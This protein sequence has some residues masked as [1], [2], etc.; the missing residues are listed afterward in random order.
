MGKV[1]NPCFIIAVTR[2]NCIAIY[3]CL[4]S[5]CN[6]EA[7]CH[8]SHQFTVPQNSLQMNDY[9][10][11]CKEEGHLGVLFLISSLS[12]SEIQDELQVC[13]C[14]RIFPLTSASKVFKT[15]QRTVY[16]YCF[17]VSG[18]AVYTCNSEPQTDILKSGCS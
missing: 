7:I 13:E 3:N 16:P 10:V 6:C 12:S 11:Q 5:C 17:H 15:L 2:L 9:F 4:F 1:F 14:I 8:N 18:A